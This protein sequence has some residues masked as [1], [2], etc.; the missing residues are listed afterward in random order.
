MASYVAEA[1]KAFIV[2]GKARRERRPAVADGG[3]ATDRRLKRVTISVF[4]GGHP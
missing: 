3:H 1:C 2:A 4:S